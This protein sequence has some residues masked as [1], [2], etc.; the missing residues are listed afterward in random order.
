MRNVLPG[1]KELR[2]DPGW[3][4]IENVAGFEVCFVFD[5]FGF[6]FYVV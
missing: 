1:L 4:L 2:K 6:K 3:V 5:L